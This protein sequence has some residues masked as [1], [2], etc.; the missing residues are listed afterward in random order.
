MPVDTIDLTRIAFPSDALTVD[1][2]RKAFPK[3]FDVP[4][5]PEELVCLNEDSMFMNIRGVQCTFGG[6][7]RME[8]HLAIIA[9]KAASSSPLSEDESCMGREEIVADLKGYYSKLGLARGQREASHLIDRIETQ[10]KSQVQYAAR[11]LTR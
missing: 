6:L 3:S 5:T 7:I 9:Y 1:T 4:S 11:G 10:A 8:R 2:I